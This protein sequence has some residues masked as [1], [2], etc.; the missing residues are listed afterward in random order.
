MNSNFLAA[1]LVLIGSGTL[2]AADDEISARQVPFCIHLERS[3]PFEKFEKLKGKST[4]EIVRAVG[5][6]L[7]RKTYSDGTQNWFYGGNCG[8]YLVVKNKC[9]ICVGDLERQTAVREGIDEE[10]PSLRDR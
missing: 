4:A 6:P 2:F 5:N 9:V 1:S 7:R 3:I 8:V 10:P